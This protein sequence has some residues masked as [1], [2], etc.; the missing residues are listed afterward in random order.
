MGPP[1][2]LVS[3]N[4]MMMTGIIIGCSAFS[5]VLGLGMSWIHSRIREKREEADAEAAQLH[6]ETGMAIAAATIDHILE[7]GIDLTDVSAR[8]SVVSARWKEKDIGAYNS[9]KKGLENI[10]LQNK[11]RQGDETTESNDQQIQ[12]I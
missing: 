7:N 5:I 6:R 1:S 9:Q 2:T 12:K 10:G 11:R 3:E 8:M 4:L